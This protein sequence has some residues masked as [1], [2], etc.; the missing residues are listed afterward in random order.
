MSVDGVPNGALTP[1]PGISIAFLSLQRENAVSDLIYLAAGV[2][3][4]LLF[5]GYAALLRRA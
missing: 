1:I 5:A 4:V 2:G 3:V